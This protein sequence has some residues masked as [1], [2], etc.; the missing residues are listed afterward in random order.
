MMLDARPAYAAEYGGALADHLP[1]A[2]VALERMGADRA[3]REAFAERYVAAK[4]LRVLKRDDAELQAREALHE[5]MRDHGWPWVLRAELR[6]LQWGLGAGAFHAFIR[7]AYGI[8]EDDSREIAA[9]LVYWRKAALDVGTASRLTIDAQPFDPATVLTRVRDRLGHVPASLPTGA[10]IAERM[11]AIAR[12]PA[13]DIACG[14]PRI[15]DEFTARVA[16]T[17]VRALATTRNFTLL[18]AMTATHAL[19]I[20]EPYAD[21][22]DGLLQSFWRAY[23]AAWV[24]AGALPLRDASDFFAEL[25]NTPAWD[26][27]LPLA[28][29]SDDEHVIKVTYTAWSE[30]AVYDNPLYRV[31][32]ARYVKLI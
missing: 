3:R 4:A 6:S 12:N 9:A 23:V 30:D 21:D 16:A 17:T 18:H 20:I 32:V 1:M 13:F 28:C 26:E 11:H 8:L 24:S 22:R 14:R 7:V 27:L 15:A 5:Q 25:A 2:L 31:A 19:R 29:A 10:L